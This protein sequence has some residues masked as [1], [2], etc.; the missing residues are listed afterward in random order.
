MV[1][2][3]PK[4]LMTL[5][6]VFVLSAAGPWVAMSTAG[7]IIGGAVK[8]SDLTSGQIETITVGDKEFSEFGYQYTGDMPDAAGV[9]VVPIVDDA[10]NF[11]VQFQGA[12]I[13]LA[14]SGGGSDALITYTVRVTDPRR[15]ISDAHIQ[16][17]PNLLGET[18]SISVTE[19]FLPLGANAEYTMS[20]F[21]DESIPTPR[22]VDWTYFDPP[23]TELRVQKDILAIATQ[24]ATTGATSAT[25]SWVDQTFS[26]ID[27]PEP[28]TAGLLLIG[29]AVM[30]LGKRREQ[31]RSA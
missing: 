7:T 16:G 29:V 11:G 3:L 27:V 15:L 21:D 8:L 31:R 20:I 24:A 4:V 26:Q 13:D 19:T 22:L 30:A 10:G 18:G 28:M 5:G 25:L 17:N 9:N 6:A 23:V 2:R 12:F 14:S 1:R